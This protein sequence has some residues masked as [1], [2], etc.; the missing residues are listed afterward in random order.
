MHK[1]RLIGCL[2]CALIVFVS[3][4]GIDAKA[5]PKESTNAPVVDARNAIAIDAKSKRVLYERNAHVITPMAS[6][7]KIVTALVALKYGDINKKVN[8][9]LKAASIR[10]SVVGYKKGE[11]ITIRELLYGLMLRSGNDAAIAIAEGISGSIEQFVQLMNEYATEIG[12]VDTHFESPHG[13]D[14]ALHYTTAYDLAIATAK[15]K[16]IDEFNKI[17]SSKDIDAGALGFTRGFHNINKILWQIPEANGVKTGFTGQ[18]GKCLVTSIN[19]GGND[20]I[21]VVINCTPRWKET[22]RINDFIS[23]VYDIKNVATKNEI[24]KTININSSKESINL[25]SKEDINVAIKKGSSIDIQIKVPKEIEAP[26]FKNQKLGTINVY[27]DNILV[28]STPLYSDKEVIKKKGLSK[29][30][31]IFK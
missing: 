25:L 14:S 21:I 3:C 11:E 18:A 30:F 28:Y 22:K 8:I 2:L 9:S 12:L 10:G 4:F 15:A 31:R 24:I 7:T 27:E 16:E 1:K 13:L 29:L 26:I 5:E 6:T 19:K 23:D 20:I 17:V